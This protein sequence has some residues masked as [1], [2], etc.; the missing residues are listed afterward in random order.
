MDRFEKQYPLNARAKE[1]EKIVQFAGK[2]QS[3]QLIS[4]PGAGRSTVLRLLAYNEKIREHHLKEKSANYLFVY[5]NF[6]ELPSLDTPSL[7][8]TIF[9]SL[10]AGI[11]EFGP[12]KE[13]WTRI[14][15]EIYA[16]FK[17]AVSLNDNFV[18]SEYLKKTMKQLNNETIIPVFLF[19]RFSEFAENIQPD[20][21]ASLKATRIASNNTLAV[22]FSTHRSLENLLSKTHW[23]DFYE[24]LVNNHIYLELYDSIATNFRLDVLE[25]EY[26]NKIDPDIREI[27]VKLTGGHGRLMKLGAQILLTENKKI[28]KEDIQDILLDDMLIRDSLLEI[29]QSLTPEERRI[30]KEYIFGNTTL[31]QFN[32]S[33]IPKLHLPFPLISEFIR[34]N[35]PETMNPKTIRIHEQTNEIFFGDDPIAGLTAYEFKLLKFL[36]DNPDRVCD[37]NEIINAVWSDTKSQEGVS[38]EALDQMT[39]RLRKKIEDE[40]DNPKHLLTIKGRGFRFLP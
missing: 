33:T 28:A 17:E 15:K 10:L 16:I 1:I 18:L 11:R 36:L 37:R 22:V 24:L 23:G 14:G 6:A 34:R 7:Q 9:L 12:E 3:S 29:W 25:K 8:K 21:F 4:V 32:N 27:L 40:A 35:I 19:D 5:I 26:G 39:Y 2:K 38:D 31:E 30:L 13:P 20:F